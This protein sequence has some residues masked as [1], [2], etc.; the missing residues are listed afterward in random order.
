MLTVWRDN[1]NV[2]GYRCDWKRSVWGL[3][4]IYYG[5]S[6][7]TFTLIEAGEAVKF[8]HYTRRVVVLAQPQR[9]T[10]QPWHL[11]LLTVTQAVEEAILRY[12]INIRP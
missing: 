6:L 4:H 12:W 10:H 5:I 9:R 7:V 11:I 2:R 3:S 1:F 8:E